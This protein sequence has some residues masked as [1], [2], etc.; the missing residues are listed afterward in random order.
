MTAG[1]E[2]RGSDV[3]PRDMDHRVHSCLLSQ[4]VSFLSD[5]AITG[6]TNERTSFALENCRA[7]PNI[8]R[9]PKLSISNGLPNRTIPNS[10]AGSPN[11]L[12]D[13]NAWI[14][15]SLPYIPS[16]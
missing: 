14:N 6:S 5:S 7:S 1:P 9:A 15:S 12:P 2:S 13:S 16:Q 11:Y 10:G 4:A 8:T 3:G